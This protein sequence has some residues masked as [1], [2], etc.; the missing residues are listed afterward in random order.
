MSA[1]DKTKL[2]AYPANG[3]K[4]FSTTLVAGS[5]PA[6][7][8]PGL[9][10]TSRITLGRSA[11]NASTALGELAALTAD[12][13]TGGSGSFIVRAL[14]LGTPGTPLAGDLSSVEAHVVL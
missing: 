11:V 6:V 1:A 12:R 2:D 9:A 5:S 13:V 8:C 7:S 3:M 4:V 14:T 10:S